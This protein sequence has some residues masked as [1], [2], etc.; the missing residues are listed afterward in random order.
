M[1]DDA[2]KSSSLAPGFHYAAGKGF[3]GSISQSII[4]AVRKQRR[5]ANDREDGMLGVSKRLDR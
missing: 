1:A 3:R 2:L 5:I 4:I